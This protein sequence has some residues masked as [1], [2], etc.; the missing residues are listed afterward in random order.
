MTYLL[1]AADSQVPFEPESVA[2]VQSLLVLLDAFPPAVRLLPAEAVAA[3]AC[4][5]S[6]PLGA[7]AAAVGVGP[8][9]G[10]SCWV[11]CVTVRLRH[12]S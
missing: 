11:S 1:S 4:I 2:I 5:V 9:D 12:Q 7:A 6:L 10:C 3:A 8:T